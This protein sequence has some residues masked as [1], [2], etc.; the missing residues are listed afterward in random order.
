MLFSLLVWY[1]ETRGSRNVCGRTEGEGCGTDIVTGWK[2]EVGILFATGAKRNKNFFWLRTLRKNEKG[3][4]G[5][6]YK[7]RFYK[8]S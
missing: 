3:E 5:S 8:E 6:F 1:V 7:G 4:E 2:K